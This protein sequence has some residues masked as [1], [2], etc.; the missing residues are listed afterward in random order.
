MHYVCTTTLTCGKQGAPVRMG[1]HS[2]ALSVSLL[3]A[4]VEVSASLFMR[5]TI[6]LAMTILSLFMFLMAGST[7][8]AA[9]SADA[10]SDILTLDERAWLTENQGRIV[11]AVE[12]GYAPFVFLD[13]NSKPAGIGEDYMRLVELKLGV[14]FKRRVFSS[15]DDIFE[16]LRDG[17]V[18]IVNA[19]TK[20]V[21]RSEFLNFTEPYISVPNVIIVRKEHLGQWSEKDLA[22]RK[23]SLVRSYA[24]A[25]YLIA[26]GFVPV[27]D[28]VPDDLTGLLNVSLSRSDAAVVDLA[29]GSYLTNQKGIANLRV[30]GEVGYAVN[31]AIG[32]DKREPVLH[33]ILQ[34]GL[35]AVTDAERQQINDRWI[36]LSVQGILVDW[37]FWLAIGVGLCI[38]LMVVA[39]IS[40]WNQ[41]LRSMVNQKTRELRLFKSVFDH[42]NE[43][44]AISDASGHLIYV[45][46]SYETLF[47][48]SLEE[49][50]KLNPSDCHPPESVAI[51][52]QQIIPMLQHG[53]SWEGV[54]DVFD[55]DGRRF[56]LWERADAICDSSGK[57]LY[58]FGFMHDITESKRA[59]AELLRAKVEA[60]RANNAKSE[61]LA[62]MSH[63]LRTPLNA[64]I[65][66]TDLALVVATDDKQKGYLE[67]V[68]KRSC[69]LLA[70]IK[71]I[72]DLVKIESDRME[73][74]DEEVD[75]G[76]IIGEAVETVEMDAKAKNLSVRTSIDSDIPRIF[77][78]DSLR[79]KQ[80][81]INLVGNAVKF[82]QAGEVL[83]K[84][85]RPQPTNSQHVMPATATVL[86]SVRDTGIG[87]PAD[88]L[89][90]IF[91]A[92]SQ[93]ESSYTRS[94]GGAG[95]GLAICRRIVERMGGKIWVESEPGMGT[96]FFFALSLKEAIPAVESPMGVESPLAKTPAR[97]LRILVADDDPS[98]RQL[99][100]IILSERGH[101]M[102]VVGS[103]GEAVEAAS[104]HFF[105]LVLLDIRM[106]DMDGVEA[107]RKIRRMEADGHLPGA[108]V[109][110][111]RL[112]IIAFTA[113][114]MTGDKE[115]FLAAG[116]DGYMAKPINKDTLLNTIDTVLNTKL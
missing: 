7:A 10:A 75:I 43:A 98:T 110:R 53:K 96:T 90:M 71:D 44:C 13:S 63:E 82:T 55:A 76:V 26:K 113:F 78:G 1:F 108:G 21:T 72:L 60:E 51:V 111:G 62:T 81:L 104:R 42:S 92:F 94:F 6:S 14:R 56:P 83:V 50:Q 106:P 101:N 2:F 33:R 17:E 100:A 93:V 32:M 46:K 52:N 103:G 116:M 65:G 29:T 89:E 61:F 36:K 25:E 70:I 15:L 35:D 68:S 85:E 91:E 20:T 109:K 86:M 67:I 87:I 28:L 34:K 38:V 4:I 23:V 115:R 18:H 88:K 22:G 49:A 27:P 77:K 11:L 54:I 79:L 24:V 73:I 105:D 102:T 5:S 48:R 84:A 74:S 66:F 12:A 69:D 45:N 47:G 64:I 16:K 39:T 31:L 30:A 58:G 37:R 3:F 9:F 59:E 8:C 112:P 57:L 97:H 80:I 99:V 95:L 107:V 41:M 19:V 40:A 114:A